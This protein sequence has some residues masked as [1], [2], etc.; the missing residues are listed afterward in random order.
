LLSSV[1]ERQTD[2]G[3]GAA[4]AAERREGEREEG[5]GEEGRESGKEGRDGRMRFAF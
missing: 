2:P 1:L 5:A 4:A 3:K